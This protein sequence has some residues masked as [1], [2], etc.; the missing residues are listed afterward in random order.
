MQSCSESLRQSPNVIL[1]IRIFRLMLSMSL[2]YQPESISPMTKMWIAPDEN[3]LRDIEKRTSY[4]YGYSRL[5][6]YAAKMSAS[7]VENSSRSLD[8][9]FTAKPDFC[10]KMISFLRCAERQH[11]IF[12]KCVIWI[13]VHSPWKKKRKGLFHR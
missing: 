4:V 8:W 12:S 13:W 11:I 10:V 3:L 6:G 7:S 9:Y 2:R 1:I 5:S